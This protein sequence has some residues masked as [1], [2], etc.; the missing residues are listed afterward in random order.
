[1]SKMAENK[2]TKNTSAGLFGPSLNDQI[3]FPNIAVP[4]L[5]TP[6][7]VNSNSSVENPSLVQSHQQSSAQP[8]QPPQPHQQRAY[9]TNVPPSS[10]QGRQQNIANAYQLSQNKTG[11][12]SQLYQPIN[13]NQ[14]FVSPPPTQPLPTPP[15]LTQSPTVHNNQQRPMQVVAPQIKTSAF[16]VAQTNLHASALTNNAQSSN[17]LPNTMNNTTASTVNTD[18]VNNQTSP[19]P[20]VASFAPVAHHWFYLK[21]W[22][23]WMPFSYYDSTKLEYA[24][25]NK[26]SVTVSTDGGRS[27]VNLQTL[28]KTSIY[29]EEAPCEVR[30]CSWFYKRDSESKLTPYTID[31]A[32]KLEKE[33]LSMLSKGIYNIRVDVAPREF[34]LFHN[35]NVLVHYV[36]NAGENIDWTGEDS[37]VRP[38]VVKRGIL[39]FQDEI[40]KG[41]PDE[42]DH[43]VFVVPGIGP[44]ADMRMRSIVECV[45]DLRKNS[46]DLAW[47]HGFS[48]GSGA[49]K[50]I[51]FLPIQWHSKLRNDRSDVDRQLKSLSLPSIGKLRSFTNDTLTDILFF[52]S[53][54]YCQAICDTVVEE[55]NEL[56]QLFKSRNPNFTGSISLVGHSLGSCILFDILANQVKTKLHNSKPPTKPPQ[57]DEH[58]ELYL[59]QVDEHQELYEDNGETVE[60]TTQKQ[61][62]CTSNSMSERPLQED[63]PDIKTLLSSLNLLNLEQMF[64]DEQIDTDT[65]MMCSESDLRD[66]QIPFG[67]RKK[68][69]AYIKDRNTNKDTNTST[70]E[71][72][73]NENTSLLTRGTQTAV[74]IK[75]NEV[76]SN[77]ISESSSQEAGDEVGTGQVNV[78]YAKLSFST[79]ALF[80][81][82]SPLGLFL[83][84]RG[85][86]SLGLDYKLPKCKTFMNIF[87]PY[88]PVVYR[89]EP[90]INQLINIAPVLIPHH[91]GRKRF[92]LEIKEN[93]SRVSANLKSGFFQ[94]VNRTWSSIN[95]FARAHTA[96]EESGETMEHPQ[97]LA[98]DS[99]DSLEHQ[100]PPQQPLFDYGSLN[101]GG[102]VDH[103][104][105]E[106]P[107]EILNEYIF[108]LSSHSCYWTS[109]DTALLI[110]NEIFQNET[111]K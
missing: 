101:N 102:R 109:E 64:T 52:T 70:K 110:I 72:S 33:Y 61:T 108:A 39:E 95:D 30:R 14:G 41:E 32:D 92:H 97:D 66:L 62:S 19:I 15:T 34:V 7:P 38:K 67:P 2:N 23:Q 3:S 78:A 50:R 83:T 76:V 36:S 16:P 98:V 88:D 44:V 5:F 93:L 12:S 51:E 106:K 85:V 54:T 55:M 90:L 11:P 68:L 22:S 53:P 17:L 48:T 65:L 21:N 73:T 58:Q 6:I 89:L 107:F 10:S 63:L 80:C 46:L 13:L 84:C 25:V 60:M 47:T 99:S 40:D 105:Q 103:V 74:K 37:K 57:V 104:L 87:H 26:S 4:K 75:D 45:N 71:D 96:H 81:L 91:K 1:V 86:T 59:P 56:Y 9:P 29:Y 79:D 94:A 27:D 18:T 24:F 35:P 100:Q 82:G 28:Q 31:V 42:V 49:P 77:E 69:S 8:Q 20:S 43:L 111:K